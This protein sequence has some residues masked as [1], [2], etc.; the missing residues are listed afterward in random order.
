MEPNLLPFSVQ[1]DLANTAFGKEHVAKQ[2]LD[3]TCKWITEHP[4]LIDQEAR[5]LEKLG[6]FK[7]D[8][9]TK[10]SRLREAFNELKIIRNACAARDV[11][12]SLPQGTSWR[13]FMD[14]M[15]Q[16]WTNM[17]GSMGSL[18]TSFMNFGANAVRSGKEL[19]IA[20]AGIA[21]AMASGAGVWISEMLAGL[22]LTASGVLVFLAVVA[23][24]CV[25]LA[26]CQYFYDRNRKPF[27]TDPLLQSWGSSQ[28][29]LNYRPQQI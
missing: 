5:I 16:S 25:V 8:N 18:S 19:A 27:Q 2:A 29:Q 1:Y 3:Y 28:P 11:K 7:L 12:N 6:K 17:R 4:E 14:F 22:G 21:S 13:G 26:I 9:A 10:L 15:R 23:L 24:A 20:A